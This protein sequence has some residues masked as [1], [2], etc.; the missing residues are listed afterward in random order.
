MRLLFFVVLVVIG[1]V[2]VALEPP[3]KEDVVPALQRGG[4]VLFI[5]HGQTH[6]DQ[7]DTD[8]LN[9]DNIK[10]QRH[11]TD[12]GREQAKAIG[13][14][15]K[16]L[17]IPVGK[18]LASKLYR[19]QETARL[20]GVGE[21]EATLHVTEGGQVVTPNENQRRA[22]ALSNLLSTI[23]PSGKNIVIVSHRP[24]LQDAAGKEFGDLGE[25]EVAI[26]QPLGD[27]KFKLV[28]RV[29]PPAKWSEWAK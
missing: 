24:N 16:K 29:F 11:L 3:G 20:L 6:P 7:A 15:L 28:A 27:G 12:A 9:L 2:A 26:F 1:S 23:P 25:G 13:A 5:R 10:A 4:Y 8:P 14:A 18:I 17:V 19:A 21:V 22:A